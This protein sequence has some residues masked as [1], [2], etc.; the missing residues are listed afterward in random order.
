MGLD[1]LVRQMYFRTDLSTSVGRR[2]AWGDQ[3]K[4][5]LPPAPTMQE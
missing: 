1:G 5:P 3:A 4:K 2:D